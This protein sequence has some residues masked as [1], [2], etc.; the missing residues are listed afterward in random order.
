[1]QICEKTDKEWKLVKKKSQTCEKK[2]QK[3]LN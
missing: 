2:S 1:M 3:H